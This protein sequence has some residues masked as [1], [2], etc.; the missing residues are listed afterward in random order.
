MTAT[1]SAILRPRSTGFPYILGSHKDVHLPFLDE[2]DVTSCGHLSLSNHSLMVTYPLALLSI[3]YSP[4]RIEISRRTKMTAML[5]TVSFCLISLMVSSLT[6]CGQ[7]TPLVQRSHLLA[8]GKRESLNYLRDWLSTSSL[9]RQC[10]PVCVHRHPVA[11][12]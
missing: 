10:N 2:L 9:S 8:L 3:L 1:A 12:R 5:T 6:A 4:R 11:G 7:I